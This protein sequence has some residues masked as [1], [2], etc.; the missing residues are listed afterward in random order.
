MSKW[1]PLNR[2]TTEN[3]KNLQLPSLSEITVS[4]VIVVHAVTTDPSSAEAAV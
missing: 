4:Q 1:R 3:P 2:F